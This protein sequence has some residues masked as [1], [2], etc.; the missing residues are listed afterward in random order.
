MKDR[1][2]RILGWTVF[3]V[4]AFSA[5]FMISREPFD[6][7]RPIQGDGNYLIHEQEMV[8]K[9]EVGMYI[10]QN[11]NLFVF[12]VANELVNVYDDAGS[13]LYGIQFPDGNNGRSDMAFRDGLLCVDARSS[14]RYL[15]EGTK[16]LRFEDQSIYN[17][18]YHDLDTYFQKQYPN[19]DG[20]YTYIYVKE[21]NKFIRSVNGCTENFI[22]FPKHNRLII[23]L[24]VLDLAVLTAL[25]YWQKNRNRRK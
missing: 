23:P 14:G 4:N 18:T 2:I 17:K 24:L 10:A 9:E 22:Q 7:V 6:N 5:I 12:F 13:Y 21:E 3:C 15:F 25:A 8:P 19:T 1:L 20:E 16:L 11:D